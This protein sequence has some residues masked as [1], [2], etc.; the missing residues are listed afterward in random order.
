MLRVERWFGFRDFSRILG[1]QF[2]QMDIKPGRK[3]WR[4]VATKR[5]ECSACH[6]ELE[7]VEKYRLRFKSSS[8]SSSA[9]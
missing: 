4:S 9:G 3:A 7:R 8:A 5:V 6:R 2:C 1:C